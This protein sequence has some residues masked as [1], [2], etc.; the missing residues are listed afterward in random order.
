TVG[1]SDYALGIETG[2]MWFNT[3]T[4]YK[5]YENSVVRMVMTSGGNVG[6]GTTAPG[7]KLHIV[8]SVDTGGG[9]FKP[10]RI[11]NPSLTTG[12]HVQL[13]FGLSNSDMNQAE[14]NFNLDGGSGS[15]NNSLSFGLYGQPTILTLKGTGNVG[16]GTTTPAYKLDVSGDIRTTG[17]LVYNGGTLG[18]C[19][20][21][22]RLKN[23]LGPFIIE[24]SL[25]KL[26]QLNPVK[27]TFKKD[28]NQ[29]LTGLIAQDVLN[30]A[31]ELVTED[32]NGY[33]QIKYGELQWMQI[34]AI[35]ELKQEN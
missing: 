19:A 29:I 17:C 30:I 33:K 8:D 27:Y 32:E 5:W 14:F 15:V 6:I 35:K 23:V 13:A 22:L 25:N 21:D 9:Y 24:N 1:A 28:P 20:S 2:N 31:P 26:I 34:Q 11:Y 4:G 10:L 3:N 7:A 18:T 12:Q 16:I